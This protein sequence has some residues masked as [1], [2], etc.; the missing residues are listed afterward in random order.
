MRAAKLN[1]DKLLFWLVLFVVSL[2]M[3]LPGETWFQTKALSQLLVF[4]GFGALL[5]LGA[6]DGLVPHGTLGRTAALLS[7]FLLLFVPSMLF[8]SCTGRSLETLA[9]WLAYFCLFVLVRRLSLEPQRAEQA[10]TVVCLVTVVLLVYGLYQYFTGFGGLAGVVAADPALSEGQRADMLSRLASRRIFSTLP[11]PT[12]FAELIVI[13]LPL[14][15]HRART[16]YGAGRQ[17]A[18]AG[19]GAA[20]LLA[21]LVLPLTGSYGA[22]PVLAA[23]GFIAL[24]AGAPRWSPRRR[25]VTAAT[26]LLCLIIVFVVVLQVRGFTPWDV[27]QSHNPVSQRLLNWRSAVSIWNEHPL[28]GAGPGNFGVAYARHRLPGAN[29]TVVAHN[30][31]LHLAAEGGVLPGLSLAFLGLLLGWR[32]VRR[33]LSGRAG[34]RGTE[35]ALCYTGLALLLYACFEITVE[36][37]GIGYP[38]VFLIALGSR[39]LFPP[40]ATVP[41]PPAGGDGAAPALSLE[42][43]GGVVL[44]L[45]LT[46]AFLF[47]GSWYRGREHLSRALAQAAEGPPARELALRSAGAASRWNLLDPEPH[48]LRGALLLSAGTDPETLG[49]AGAAFRTASALDPDRAFFHERISVVHQGLGQGLAAFLEADR[50]WRLYPLQPRYRNRRAE[51]L[52]RA[53]GGS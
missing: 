30:S 39:S 44:A 20:V 12:T 52:Q 26:A 34:E 4:A 48:A 9:L 51:L 19:W 23:L 11:L 6:R 46:A 8:S 15:L 17:P 7:L 3:V 16:A 14:L 47:T 35:R 29:E 45:I 49:E 33:L 28:S 1:S 36:F 24:L 10:V 5:V 31:W 25:A 53:G 22:L 43:P 40:P 41:A 21:L 2:N 13:A 18:L 42:A 38:G 32:T 27:D 37:P 50:A